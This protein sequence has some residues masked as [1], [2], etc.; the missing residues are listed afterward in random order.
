[1]AN[2]RFQCT[3]TGCRNSFQD[4][5]G[6]RGWEMDGAAGNTLMELSGVEPEGEGCESPGSAFQAGAD[7]V[8][9]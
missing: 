5:S 8:Q 1:M 2:A 6:W 9:V 7:V 3:K 4:G